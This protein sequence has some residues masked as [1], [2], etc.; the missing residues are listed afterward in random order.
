M[1]GVTT[2]D[3]GGSASSGDLA[4]I[5]DLLSSASNVDPSQEAEWAER[6]K[7]LQKA[8][9]ALAQHVSQRAELTSSEFASIEN[10]ISVLSRQ[11]YTESGFP[12]IRPRDCARINQA[13]E[14]ALKAN[15][16][17]FRTDDPLI[18]KHFEAVVE[19]FAKT[20]VRSYPTEYLR[21]VLI[22]G[23][24]RMLRGDPAGTREI[25][26]HYADRPYLIEADIHRT[27]DLLSL[28]LQ[29][30]TALGDIRHCARIAFL[31]ALM[32]TQ[33]EPLQARNIGLKLAPFISIKGADPLPSGRLISTVGYF[34]NRIAEASRKRGKPGRDKRAKRIVNFNS[35]LLQV[36][37]LALSFRGVKPTSYLKGAQADGSASDGQDVLVTRAMG[38]IGDLLMMTPGL[39]ALS[40]KIGRPVRV[41]VP[42]KFFPVFANNPHVELV[43]IDGPPL[44]LQNYRK[45][46]NFTACPATK[47]EVRKRPNIRKDRVE[48]FAA[49]MG[50]RKSRLNEAG[51]G[52][53]IN[54][55]DAQKRFA[56]DFFRETGFGARPIIG[57]QPYSRDSYKDH[58]KIREI[59]ADLSRDYDLVLFHHSSDGLPTGKGIATTAG[60]SLQ[61]SLAL[62]SKLD[63]LVS[64][65]SAFFHAASAFD[66]PVIGMFGPTNGEILTKH[67]RR[68]RVITMSEAFPCT[69][70]WRNE[71]LPCYV[72]GSLGHS[73]CIGA[74]TSDDIRKTIANFVPAAKA[75]A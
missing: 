28:D 42:Q 8:S 64:V 25:L 68:S 39:R 16:F 11:P 20:E 31:H 58:A 2:P 51:R 48:L 43:D 63:A 10:L 70:C 59:I 60:L 3:K 54:L 47:Y 19:A 41:A 1:N 61:K 44:D 17:L 74:I 67:R 14:D 33:R 46:H 32:L 55:T 69:P 53:E 75:R 23:Q 56:E 18:G 62:V 72:T 24:T 38:G 21:A 45:W 15:E 40:K 50:V 7:L 13:L 29:A 30:R 22:H 49:A 57:V 4:E 52:V 12:K 26:A 5:I 66:I 36:A 9:R 65:D 71:D 35:R 6:L 34:A 27:L 73:P 37:L